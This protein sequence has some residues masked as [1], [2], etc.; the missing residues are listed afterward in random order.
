MSNLATSSHSS[1]SAQSPGMTLGQADFLRFADLIERHAGICLPPH[2]AS[3]VA[4]RLHRRLTAL[5]IP[6]F[7]DYYAFL[8]DASHIDKE[9]PHFINALTTNK[10]EFFREAAHFD[11]LSKQVL[12]SL[13]QKRPY[14]SAAP[15][16]VWS[17]ACSSGMEA[18]TLAMVLAEWSEQAGSVPFT[19]YGTD[20]DTDILRDAQRAVYP[21]EA[22]LTVPDALRH[23]YLLR[24]RDPKDPSV[25]VGPTLRHKVQFSQLNLL[26]GGC[27]AHRPVDI[28]FCRNVL[29][30]FNKQVQSKVLKRLCDHLAPGGYLFIGHSES[31]NGLTLP[32][33]SIAPALYQRQ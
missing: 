14:T 18:Y 2:K 4:H 20:I 10:T 11:L 8:A 3:L 29:I 19:I 28:L 26:E 15:L 12:P 33:K 1:S 13:R 23:K 5:G 32:V 27:P 16:T 24:A 21:H 30:Y 9:L 7:R 31:L 22:V 25:R 6:S 17:S